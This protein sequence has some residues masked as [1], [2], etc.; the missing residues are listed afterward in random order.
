MEPMPEQSDFERLI[1][2]LPQLGSEEF[3]LIGQRWR[4]MAVPH[5]SNTKPDVNVR[6]A[7]AIRA[8]TSIMGLRAALNELD[9]DAK[10]P[11]PLPADDE[12][13]RAIHG[14]ATAR[15]VAAALT[16]DEDAQAAIAGL[17]MV[18]L[19]RPWV[20]EALIDNVT[21]PFGAARPGF[22]ETED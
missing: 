1:A 20:P 21:S 22:F 7:E 4:D 16:D 11:V 9:P 13:N 12:L 15:D 19:L 8:A 14:G 18:L 3:L 17:G 2:E 5:R 10:S 6:V